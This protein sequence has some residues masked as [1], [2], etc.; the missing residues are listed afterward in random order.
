MSVRKVDDD[1]RDNLVHHRRYFAIGWRIASTILLTGVTIASLTLLLPSLQMLASYLAGAVVPL[2]VYRFLKKATWWVYVVALITT[3]ASG[4]WAGISFSGIC[5]VL[6][7]SAVYRGSEL[8]M[9]RCGEGLVNATYFTGIC[10]P[11]LPAGMMCLIIAF[12]NRP[13]ERR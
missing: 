7:N 12:A 10:F 6:S 9:V 8:A 3:V 11:L 4:L 13:R 2:M 5:Y 1:K